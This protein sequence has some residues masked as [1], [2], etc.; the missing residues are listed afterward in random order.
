MCMW[1]CFFSEYVNMC[2]YIIN[3]DDVNIVIHLKQ[4]EILSSHTDW[5]LLFQSL[6]ILRRFFGSSPSSSC[7]A[8]SRRLW[9]WIPRNRF[10]APWNHF[11]IQHS[12]SQGEPHTCGFGVFTTQPPPHYL[13]LDFFFTAT[14]AVVP[15][16][17]LCFRLV[18]TP[19]PQLSPEVHTRKPAEALEAAGG[20]ST[21]TWNSLTAKTCCQ[22]DAL[23]N[24]G[25]FFDPM[26]SICWQGN[27]ATASR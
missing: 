14:L 16:A 6:W 23:W 25:V 26:D 9:T 3:I 27:T 7:P 18:F 17:R 20:Q 22:R 19:K 2:Y 13:R 8:P 4:I 11:T 1:C 15:K 24:T 5:Y 10:W 21:L 12:F